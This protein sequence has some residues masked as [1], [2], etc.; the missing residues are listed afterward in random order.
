M[1]HLF[2]YYEF[3]NLSDKAQ[4]N[5]IE[6]V[7]SEMYDGN[8]S[9]DMSWVIDDDALFEPPQTEMEKLFG[10]DYIL[11]NGGR[12]MI[13][14][15]RKNIYL[16]GK[17]D[18]NYYIHCADALDVTNDNL[19][20]RWIGIPN[21]FR[22]FIYYS[23][24]NTGRYGSTTIEFE[25]DDEE[26]MIEKLGPESIGEIEGYFESAEK[27]FEHHIDWVLTNASNAYEDQFTDDGVINAIE[28]NDIV[29]HEDGEIDEENT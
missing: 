14:N 25:I 5:A 15:T 28:S 9:S 4:K 22:K 20:L 16:I 11:N 23:F 21:R 7:R 10:P 19:F 1:R 8:W 6:R 17:S 12:F 29:F 26:T 18:P 2:E 27:K 13:K 24:K 3:D